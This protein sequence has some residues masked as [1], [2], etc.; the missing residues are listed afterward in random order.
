MDFALTDDQLALAA[1]VREVLRAHCP[2][3]EVR[4]GRDRRPAWA[5]LAGVGLFAALVPE[6]HGGLGLRLADTVPALEETGRAAMP[7]PVAETVAAAPAL[8]AGEPDS[9]GGLASGKLP[10]SVRLGEQVYIPDAD[11]AELLVVES[12]GRAYALPAGTGLTHQPGVDPVRRLFSLAPS[13]LDAARPLPGGDPRLALRRVTVAT[14]AQLVGAA[15]HLLDTTVA[16][17]G[18]RRQ[19][20]APIGSFQAVKHRLADVAI[21]VEFAAPLVYRAA[22]S[23]DAARPT[24]DRDVSAAKA[25]AGEAAEQA[26]RTALQVHGAIGYTDELD[27]RL[28]LA[29][30]WS[31]AAAYGGTAPHRARLRESILSDPGRWP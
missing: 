15:R 31:L 12:G 28:W 18:T 8:L 10:V 22:L 16:Y 19:F 9:L 11:L 25:A 23:V 4:H 3:E 7:G 24:A 6:E 26:A 1:T 13:A 30:V 29:R 27:L 2:P 14:A 17:A 5:R 20:G 21:A